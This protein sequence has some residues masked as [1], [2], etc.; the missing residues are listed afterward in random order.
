MGS[1][2]NR[3]Q[4]PGKKQANHNLSFVKDTFRNVKPR[5]KKG[6]FPPARKVSDRNRQCENCD[7]YGM[8][9][10]QCLPMAPCRDCLGTGLRLR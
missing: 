3:P 5:R 10:N 9:G 8:I 4:V 2:E 1:H 7:G 6:F